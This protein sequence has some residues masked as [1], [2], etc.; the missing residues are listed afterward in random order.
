MHCHRHKP[1]VGHFQ[2]HVV[3]Q[4]M[5]KLQ[6]RKFV[7]HR[8]I[9]VDSRYS[10]LL[11]HSSYIIYIHDLL[12]ELATVLGPPGKCMKAPHGLVIN[13]VVF[14]L[15]ECCTILCHVDIPNS[16]CNRIP[17]FQCRIERVADVCSPC[18]Q[19]GITRKKIQQNNNKRRSNNVKQAAN[20]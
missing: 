2:Q 6:Q 19:M 12:S 17:H 18:N 5:R 13:G 15:H 1:C 16:K 20:I 7:K 8:Q 11:D 10:R 14:G 3:A 4:V 9:L